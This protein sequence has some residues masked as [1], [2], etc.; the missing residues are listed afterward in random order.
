MPLRYYQTAANEALINALIAG[1][2]RPVVCMPTGSG[3]SPTL[4]TLVAYLANKFPTEK[5]VVAVHTQELVA[6]LAATYEAISGRKPAVNSASLKRRERGQVTFCQIQSVYNNALQF[7]AIKLLVI[8]EAD[9][10]PV[11]GD[12]QYRTFITEALIANPDMRVCGFTATP[13]RTGSGLVYGKDQPFDELVYDIG[14]R[15]LMDDGFLS[16]LVSKDGGQPDLTGVHVRKGEYV[17]AELEAIMTDDALVERACDEIVKYGQDRH[18]WLIFAS[19]LKH[20]NMLR[21]KMLQRGY[22]LPVIEG[23]MS[24]KERAEHILKFKNKQLR[25]LININVLSVGFDAPH[26]DLLALTRPTLSPGLYYQQIGRGLRIEP[27]KANCLVLDLAGNISRHGPID[28]LNER[29]KTKR[30][31]DVPGEAPTKTCVNCKEIVPAGV[32]VC[33]V[34][35]TEFPAIAVAKH[36][37]TASLESALSTSEIKLL[38]VTRWT[39]RVHTPRDPS[40][41]PTIQVSYW[42]G[43]NSISEWLSVD[44]DANMYAKHKALSWIKENPGYASGKLR[45]EGNTIYGINEGVEVRLDTATACAPWLNACLL[46]PLH[47]RYQTD[48]NGGPFPRVLSRI[49]DDPNVLGERGLAPSAVDQPQ[50]DH[51]ATAN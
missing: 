18:G 5:I 3:K 47:I 51:A 30:K 41:T 28:T 7:G 35:Q 36:A 11:E 37:P 33:P 19:G 16:P 14:I 42:N 13:Y 48:P 31:S 46:K 40:K 38:A 27:G 45:I 44:K 17:S 23:R 4:C 1:C 32:R 24:K 26:V 25:G 6:Q 15:Q 12:G 9:R 39:L 21:E 10:C 2:K 43:L 22:D 8:D 34:C 50:S 20:A 29:I 49:Y